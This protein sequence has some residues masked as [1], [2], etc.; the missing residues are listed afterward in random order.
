MID[1]NDLSNLSLEELVAKQKSLSNVQK[2]FI[3]VEVL[4]VASTLYAIYKES[5]THPFLILGFLFLIANN[6]SK[7]KKVE[8]EL[9]KRKS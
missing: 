3:V 5:K 6:G 2:L 4:L 9:E 8:A 7:L 1:K